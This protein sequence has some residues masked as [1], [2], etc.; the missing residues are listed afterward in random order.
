MLSVQCGNS[1]APTV[2]SRD[3]AQAQALPSAP[4]QL[5][6]QQVLTLHHLL[7]TLALQSLT[8]LL[9]QKT[10]P[11]HSTASPQLAAVLQ[12]ASEESQGRSFHAAEEVHDVRTEADENRA[13]VSALVQG[14]LQKAVAAHTRCA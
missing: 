12:T 14:A 2:D 5:Q 6:A 10:T 13:I 7:C 4:S 3:Y 11:A 9:R 8:L 1:Q